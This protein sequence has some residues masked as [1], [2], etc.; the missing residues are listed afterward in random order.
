MPMRRGIK[1]GEY[2]VVCQVCQAEYYASEL[3]KRYDG[4]MVCKHDNDLRNPADLYGY[5]ARPQN[6]PYTSPRNN[7]VTTSTLSSCTIEGR[8]AY[9]GRAIAGCMVAGLSPVFP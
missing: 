7:D 5:I 3:V 1:H 2:K 4:L 8:S 6:V 9:A